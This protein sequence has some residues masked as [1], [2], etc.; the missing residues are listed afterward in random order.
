MHESIF[1]NRER[2][3]RYWYSG[4]ADFFQN[5]GWDQWLMI[6]IAL[7]CIY[8]LYRVFKTY[9]IASDM[10]RREKFGA[11]IDFVSYLFLISITIDIVKNIAG[12][13]KKN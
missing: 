9:F 6:V 7:I 13:N 3:L 4:I 1:A 5:T 2:P 8:V 11:F 12:Y 10:T